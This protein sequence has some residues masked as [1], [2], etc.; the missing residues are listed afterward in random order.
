QVEANRY[1]GISSAYGTLSA[2]DCIVESNVRIGIHLS[3]ATADLES[4]QV[5]DTQPDADGE[6]GVGIHIDDQSVVTATG[7]LVQGDPNHGEAGI[8]LQEESTLVATECIVREN[9]EVGLQL[10]NGIATLQGVEVLDTQTDADGEWGRGIHLQDGSTLTATDCLVQ[11]NLDVGV[12][13]L[14]STAT[15]DDCIVQ[16]NQTA[17][18]HLSSSTATLEGVQVLDTQPDTDGQFGRG[19]TVQQASTLVATSCLVQGNHETGVYVSGATSTLEGVQVLGTHRVTESTVAFGL[20]SQAEAVVD[21]TNL[22]V[23]DTDGPALYV[24]IEALVNCTGCTLTDNAF[25]GALVQAG[26]ALLMDDSLVEGTVS[27]SNAGA[28]LGVFVDDRV[29]TAFGSSTLTLHDSVLR[30]NEMGAVYLRGGGTYQLVGNEL[31]GGAG[32][33]VEP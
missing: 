31:S 12:F 21:A 29:V 25:A 15:L 24:A 23:G 1:T 16:D 26:G 30:D 13:M 19:I 20:V 4:V 6:W 18:I 7:C 28:G 33:A 17:G 10:H 3:K 27:D 22:E 11:G 2:T 5:I 8:N 9:H 14:D 32:L